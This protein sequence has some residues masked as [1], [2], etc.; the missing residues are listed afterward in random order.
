MPWPLPMSTLPPLLQPE[1]SASMLA[2]MRPCTAVF[3][4]TWMS[5]AIR[6]AGRC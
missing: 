3:V 6:R 4:F 2:A 5:L 1:S